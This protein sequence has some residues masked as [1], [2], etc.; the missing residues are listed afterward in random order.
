[1]RLGGKP[2]ARRQQRASRRRPDERAHAALRHRPRT[3][4]ICA[5]SVIHLPPRRTQMSV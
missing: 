1:L 5:W 3:G 4:V 2:D